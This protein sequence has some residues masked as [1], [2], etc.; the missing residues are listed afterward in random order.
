MR[1]LRNLCWQWTISF[2]VFM[3][4]LLDV[5][6][7]FTDVKKCIT[8]LRGRNLLKQDHVCCNQNASKVM[9]ISLTDREIFNAMYVMQEHQLE[10]ALTGLNQN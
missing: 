4:N 8:F 2:L 9:D 3:M 7:L 1:S 6:S 10:T 5:A